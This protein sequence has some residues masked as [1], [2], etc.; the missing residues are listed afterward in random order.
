MGSG[1]PLRDTG[2]GGERLT[3]AAT[4]RE[5]GAEGERVLAP[6]VEGV[7]P[8]EAL[9]LGEAATLALGDSDAPNDAL[10]LA[11]GEALSVAL[12]AMT[13]DAVS[14]VLLSSDHVSVTLTHCA[15]G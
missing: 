3:L 14:V 15:C 2:G 7:A 11:L 8:A 6:L 13:P 12:A 1:V 10:A 5:P 9:P 4:L